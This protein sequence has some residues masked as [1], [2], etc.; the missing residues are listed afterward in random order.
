MVS[1]FI[2]VVED[3]FCAA[4]FEAC[5]QRLSW[6]LKFYTAASWHVVALIPLLTFCCIPGE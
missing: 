6:M 2:V 4:F 1:P 5:Q 3:C